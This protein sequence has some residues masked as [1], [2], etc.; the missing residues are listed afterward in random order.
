[1]IKVNGEIKLD[2]NTK[3]AKASLFADTKSEVTSSAMIEGLPSG[4][5]ME[6]GSS[7]LTASGEFAFMKSDGTWNWIS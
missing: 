4:Y 3:K 7:I 5:T 1:M 2:A 6:A